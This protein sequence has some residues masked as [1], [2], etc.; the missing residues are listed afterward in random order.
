MMD[1]SRTGKAGEADIILGIAKTGGSDI[2]NTM[3]I[4]CIQEQAERMARRNQYAHR[5]SQGDVL[6]MWA[7]V[8][9]FLGLK[10]M[11]NG[12]PVTA[13]LGAAILISAL[14]SSDCN[15]C[16]YIRCGNDAS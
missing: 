14:A 8:M 10:M 1:N 2:E 5:C 9:V 11:D 4:L 15:E 12:E 16:S 3:R 7:L 6:L 13:V